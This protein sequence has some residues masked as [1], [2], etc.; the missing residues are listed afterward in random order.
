MGQAKK[1][2]R[3]LS[4]DGGGIRGIIPGIIL[5][6]LED[7]LKKKTGNQNATI[8]QY[9]D[10][11]A[12]TSTGGILSLVYLC[13]DRHGNFKYGARDALSMYIDLG[14]DIFDLSLQK[15]MQSLAGLI[16]E[17]YSESELENILAQFLQEIKLSQAL[18][19]CLI[20]SYDI[21]NRKSFFFTSADADSNVYDFLM[22]D[23]ARATSAAP[24]YFEAARI[25]SLFGSPYALVDGGVFANNPSLCAYA[26]VR[27]IDFGTVLNDPDKPNKP[28]AKDMLMVSIGTGSV[29]RPYTYKEYKDAGV[30]KWIK[31][32][33]DIM[34]SGN[35]ETVDFQLRKIYETLSKKDCGDYYRIQPKLINSNPDMDK[36]DAANILALQEDGLLAV[37]DH[38][39][40]LDEIVDKLIANE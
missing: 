6:Y 9:F 27:G 13:P 2:I 17:K 36:A 19:P 39:V 23:V 8:G 24:T 12:G 16:D 11:M 32:L 18:K 20:T 38:K 31:P 28:S 22:R 29:K 37:A 14:N 5:S 40:L 34:M 4:L 33:I 35:A 15:Q 3:I 30:I 26:E 1:K 21:R 25:K 7:E 10:F